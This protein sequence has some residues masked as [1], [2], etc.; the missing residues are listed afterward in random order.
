M[1]K[2]QLGQTKV[3]VSRLIYGTEPFNFKKGPDENRAQGDK[4]P[5]EAAEILR[6]A[7]ELGVNTWDTSDD[8]GTHPHVAEALKLVKRKEAVIADKS[9]SLSEKDGWKALAFSQKSLGTD[10]VDIM[11]MHIVPFKSA[12]RKDALGRPYYSGTV[13]ERMGTLKAWNDAKET[14]EIRA[15]A[16]STHSTKVLRQVLNIPDI[17]IVCTTLNIQGDFLDDGK[18]DERIEAIKELKED[19]RG[20]YVIKLLNAGRLKDRGDEAI[21]WCLQYHDFIDAWNIGMYNVVEVKH[22]LEL[23]KRVL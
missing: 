10:Y 21:E 2:I 12:Y 18:L 3:R 8:Y 15:T 11:F 5:T 1:Q 19:D 7:L 14:G 17:D 9:N 4:T 13:Y 16:L 6:D 20:V 22:N 23:F